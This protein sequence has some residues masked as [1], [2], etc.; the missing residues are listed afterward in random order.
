MRGPS[1]PL[2]T[3]VRRPLALGLAALALAS[4][5]SIDASA[6]PQAPTFGPVI[7]DYAAY[8][9]QSRCRPKPKPGVVAF[10]AML[11][12]A[13]PDGAWFA[14][15]RPCRDAGLSE[16]KEGRALDWSRSAA[17]PAERATVRDLFAWL[18]ADDPH[19]NFDA[20]ARRL[21]IMY[22]VWNRKI[23]EGWSGQWETYCI[24]RGRRCKDPDTKAVLHPHTDHVH[25]SFTWAGA[26]VE[27]SY[28]HPE[29]SQPVPT[30]S[31]SP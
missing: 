11:E 20:M 12:Q 27:T 31:P 14:I 5:Q 21:G 2:A 3:H 25:F 18:F 22:I 16:H 6:A 13:Y 28:W 30:P 15:S 23:W 29:L 4:L 24:Q 26:R 1:H 9:G 19:G 7:E 10:Q 8:E 17:V